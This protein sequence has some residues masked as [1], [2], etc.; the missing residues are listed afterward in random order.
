MARR[1]IAALTSSL[2]LLGVTG[3]FV[4]AP[5]ASAARRPHCAAIPVAGQPGTFVVVCSTARA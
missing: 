4:A 2:L 3:A 1:R 5:S